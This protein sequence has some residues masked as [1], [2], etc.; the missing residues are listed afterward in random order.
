MKTLLLRILCISPFL[1]VNT[2]VLIGSG[3]LFFDMAKDGWSV[4]GV[5]VG[6]VLSGLLLVLTAYTAAIVVCIWSCFSEK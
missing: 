4:F 1:L 5:A 2:G 6:L 3:C